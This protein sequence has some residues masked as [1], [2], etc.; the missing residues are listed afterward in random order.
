[1]KPTF[2]LSSL[3]AR[4]IVAATSVPPINADAPP[5]SVVGTSI[6]GSEIFG[7]IVVVEVSCVC[8]PALGELFDV[9]TVVEDPDVEPGFATVVEVEVTGDGTD[10]VD[11]TT[12][13]DVVEVVVVT[14]LIVTVEAAVTVPGPV[15]NAASTT[16]LAASRATT[17]PSDEHVTLTVTDVFAEVAV[18]AK[19]HGVAVPVAEKSLAAIPETVSEKVNVYESVRVAEGDDGDDQL[20][21]G[22]VTSAPGDATLL[23][24]GYPSLTAGSIVQIVEKSHPVNVFWS[25]N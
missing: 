17:V 9:T 10:V 20:A 3:F 4:V 2:T 25:F 19:E 23:K 5:T 6:S 18:G 7:A 22:A 1:M 15:F 13:V 8:T 12:D 21:V 16:E 14:A 24:Y 11:P